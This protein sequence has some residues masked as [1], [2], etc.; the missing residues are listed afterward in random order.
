M[1]E[2]GKKI[3]RTQDLLDQ[4]IATGTIRRRRFAAGEIGEKEESL[5]FQMGFLEMKSLSKLLELQKIISENLP[6]QEIFILHDEEYFREIFSMKR[7]VIGVVCNGEL[8]GYSFI[9][10]P[11][12]RDDGLCENLGIDLGLTGDNLSM[13]IHLQGLAVHP[14]YRGNDLQRMMAAAH[15]HVIE[16]M[17]YVHACCTVSPKNLISLANLLSCGLLIEGL[18]PKFKGWWRFILHRSTAVPD[19]SVANGLERRQIEFKVPIS[20][21]RLQTELLKKGFKGREIVMR[22]LDAEIVYTKNECQ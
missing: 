10:I 11:G 14:A 2:N 22:G 7:S 16:E 8:V 6:S 9:L 5:E 19:S 15:L 18:R 1:P 13:V 4:L 17:G 12:L 3:P 21:L 20:D